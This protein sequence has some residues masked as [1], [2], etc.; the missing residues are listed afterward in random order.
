MPPKQTSVVIVGTGEFGRHHA[1]CVLGTGDAARI[2]GFVE[3]GAKPREAMAQRFAE[4]TKGAPPPPFYDTIDDFLAAHNGSADCAVIATPHSLHAPQAI[5]CMR[6]GMDVLPEKPMTLNAA[7]ARRVIRARDETGRVLTVAFPASHSNALRKAKEIIASG[8]IGK[9][10]SIS[11]TLFQ[12]WLKNNAGTWRQIPEISG[13]GLLFDTGAHV[14][15]IM[16]EITGSDVAELCVAQSNRGTPVDVS[17]AIAGRFKNNIFFT[18]CAEGSA[19]CSAS[20]VMVAC[21]GGVLVLGFWGD[22]L[23][24]VK[25]GTW[26]KEESIEYPP[27][28]SVFEQ[29]LRVRAGTLA[30]PSPAEAGLRVAKFMDRVRKAVH[31]TT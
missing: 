15:N 27:N 12:P 13:G 25:A 5:A 4:W 1:H 28:T 18:F 22:S 2:A 30:N 17:S 11:A 20:R 16:F 19:P 9:V 8:E 26:E 23:R 6:A 29:F 14:L 21:T 10:M 24:I 7:E 31:K 3:P